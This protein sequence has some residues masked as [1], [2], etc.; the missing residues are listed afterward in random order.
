MK[1]LRYGLK[2]FKCPPSPRVLCQNYSNTI[3]HL[4]HPYF[5]TGFADGESCF[6]IGVSKD[7]KNYTGYRVK[8][9]FQ[10]G[11]HEKDRALLE[12]IQNYF[13]G[14]GSIY[15]QSNRDVVIYS[16]SSI[17]DLEVIITHFDKYPL[18]TQK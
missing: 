15:K 8:A 16:V 2:P 7:S 17:T 5:I 10:I 6:F 13:D 9:H 14:V 3:N 18:I 1:N 11:L 4:L 12:E